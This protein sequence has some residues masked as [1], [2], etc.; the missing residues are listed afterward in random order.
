MSARKRPNSRRNLD[1]AIE[2][3]AEDR[4]DPLRTRSA[5]ASAIV[6][7]MLPGGVVNQVAS[8]SLNVLPTVGEAVAWANDLVRKIDTA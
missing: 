1:I 5:L 7:Q 2:R 6:A 3:L 8:E 4:G